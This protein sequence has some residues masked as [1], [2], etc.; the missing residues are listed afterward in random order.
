MSTVFKRTALGMAIAAA[1][2]VAAPVMAN[3]N[4][5]IYGQ[6]AISYWV[7]DHKVDTDENGNK[8]QQGDLDN[9]SRIGVRGSKDF[10]NGPTFIWQME[11]GN[12]GDNGADGSFGV[13]DTFAGFKVD[14]GQLRFGRVLT[15]L[16]EVVDWPYTNPGLGNVFDWNTDI[17]AGAHLDRQ[18]DQFRWDSKDY[19]GFSYELAAGYHS[20]ASNDE[21][22]FGAAAHY[23]VGFFTAH[24]AWQLDRGMSNDDFTGT[25]DRTSLFAGAEFHFDNGISIVGAVKHME[26]DYDTRQTLNEQAG[27]N[28]Q[29]QLAYSATAQ[30]VTGDWLFK[31]GYAATSKLES[32]VGKVADT[33]D[34]AITGRVMYFVDPSAVIYSD[35]RS[36][37]MDG[38]DKSGDSTRWG[39]GVEYYF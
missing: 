25:A 31:L 22:F 26:S 35:I 6:A 24:L 19:S 27:V 14:A 13:R 39:V 7:I 3:D 38:N 30:Y 32:N 20:G 9:E 21:T 28:N 12:V 16:Y 18:G 15:P 4:V 36:Y 34:Q 17:A 1:A 23:T 29:E 10:K 11:S 5:E 33:E 37:D 2:M 8:K